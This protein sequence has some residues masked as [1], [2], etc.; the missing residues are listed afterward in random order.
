MTKIG[1]INTSR[2][3][4]NDQRSSG[5]VGGA[6]FALYNRE[7]LHDGLRQDLLQMCLCR[8]FLFLCMWHSPQIQILAICLNAQNALSL[9]GIPPREVKA[10]WMHVSA[11]FVVLIDETRVVNECTFTRFESE[12]VDDH[13]EGSPGPGVVATCCP[14]ARAHTHTNTH[15]L[16]QKTLR[17]VFPISLLW[18]IIN[19]K[20]KRVHV[21]V[22]L[23][24][25]CTSINELLHMIKFVSLYLHTNAIRKSGFLSFFPLKYELSCR[26][27]DFFNMCTSSGHIH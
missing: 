11:I 4:K 15:T 18:Q 26:N 8:L 21:P 2:E 16:T 9:P 1:S 3:N 7:I 23:S 14:R 13:Q 25:C 24:P 10:A 20:K 22:T 17:I 5:T 19:T 6:G 27:P 12:G